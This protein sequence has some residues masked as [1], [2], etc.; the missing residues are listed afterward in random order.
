[1]ENKFL[2]IENIPLTLDEINKIKSKSIE[3]LPLNPSEQGF[4]GASIRRKIYAPVT[5]EDGSVLSEMKNKLEIVQ[6]VF[7]ETVDEL[8][9]IHEALLVVPEHETLLKR[10]EPNQHTMG[11]ITGLEVEM[12]K[13]IDKNAEIT[14]GTAVKI[15]YDSKGFVVGGSALTADD[16]PMITMEH[17]NNLITILQSKAD[18]VNGKLSQSQTNDLSITDTFIVSILEDVLT[19]SNAHKGDVAIVTTPP[20]TYILSENDYS[21]A[22][23]WRPL[24]TPTD[25]VLSVNG[26]VGTVLLDKTSIGLGNVENSSD[27]DKPVS[28]LQA[29]AFALKIDK[30]F[31]GYAVRNFSSLQDSDSILINYAG[32]IARTTVDVLKSYF[33]IK[34]DWNATSGTASEILN[35]PTI[36]TK[37]EI[38]SMNVFRYKGT[39]ATYDNLPSSGNVVGDV[40]R[41]TDE[42]VNYLRISTGWEVL[43]GQGPRG[44]GFRNRGIWN[45]YI[46]YVNDDNNID[47]VSHNNNVYYA[48]KETINQAP[49]LNIAPPTPAWALMIQGGRTDA[50]IFT[51]NLVTGTTTSIITSEYPYQLGDIYINTIG[52][53]FQCVNIDGSSITWEYRGSLRGATGLTGP[54]GDTGTNLNPRGDWENNVTYYS[55]SDNKIDV[56]FY[57]GTSYYAKQ[58][59]Y[60]QAPAPISIYWGILASG[61][62][63]DVKFY[64]GIVVS[65]TSAYIEITDGGLFEVG[66]IYINTATSGTSKG[67]IYQCVEKNG[68]SAFFAY[69]TNFV[70]ADGPRGYQGIQGAVGDSG[71]GL[72]TRGQWQSGISYVNDSLY[73][74]IVDYNEHSYYCITSNSDTTSPSESEKWRMYAPGGVSSTSVIWHRGSVVTGTSTFIQ[75]EALEINENDYYINNVTG[76]LYVCTLKDGDTATWSYQMNLKG[77]DGTNGTDGPRGVTGRH[78]EPKGLWNSSTQYKYENSNNNIDVVFYEGATY[79]CKVASSTSQ[80]PSENPSSWQLLSGQRIAHIGQVK[81]F[82]TQWSPTRYQTVIDHSVC[83]RYATTSEF[84]ET[85]VE[86]VYYDD[87]S[88][89]VLFKWIGGQYVEQQYIVSGAILLNDITNVFVNGVVYPTSVEEYNAVSNA[90]IRISAFT[91]TQI[92]F[93]CASTAPTIHVNVGLSGT[94]KDYTPI[95]TYDTLAQFPATGVVGK[96]YISLN[97]N[98]MYRWNGDEYVLLSAGIAPGETADVTLSDALT[99]ADLGTSTDVI[100]ETVLKNVLDDV[101]GDLESALTSILGV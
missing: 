80:I 78:F 69:Q 62:R 39:K 66:D 85:G 14:P 29:Q 36:Y 6:E 60:N 59:S 25:L 16:I 38:D 57:G 84:P 90:K 77:V 44:K 43:S 11:A 3:S 28:T 20:S 21:I 97:N 13:K 4:S 74:D 48:L 23:N 51:G 22:E 24:K 17:I 93:F 46:T 92:T 56:V 37:S 2:K 98:S 65:G 26:Q 72:R 81:L 82:S 33:N 63:T 99:Y 88:S 18:L 58:N 34:S 61:G 67:N 71:K 83:E 30:D 5:G 35:K 49:H 54:K 12:A 94:A 76:N 53:F 79:Y 52:G 68:N 73:I 87:I 15:T 1:M 70:G 10:N 86:N 9:I 41:V 31:S 101:L 7:E 40:W 95:L 45:N 100:S 75:S 50:G 89:G 19:L 64:N 47:V 32:T 55:N 42:N 91:P 8:E 96:I 27:A